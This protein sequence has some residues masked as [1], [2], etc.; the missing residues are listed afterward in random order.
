M[1]IRDVKDVQSLIFLI[2][3]INN[4]L[5]KKLLTGLLLFNNF[6]YFLRP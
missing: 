1:N 2:K 6:A 4:F 3:P 5:D